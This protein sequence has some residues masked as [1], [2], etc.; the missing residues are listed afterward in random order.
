MTPS[1]P[2]TIIYFFCLGKWTRLLLIDFANNLK[3]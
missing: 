3:L 2:M 1:I